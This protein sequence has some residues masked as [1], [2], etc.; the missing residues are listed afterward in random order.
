MYDCNF[1]PSIEIY[2]K[3]SKIL[4]CVV[5]G[6]VTKGPG[7]IGFEPTQVVHPRTP[8]S[9]L[10]EVFQAVQWQHEKLGVSMYWASRTSELQNSPHMHV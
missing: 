8:L 2:S 5:S 7:G 3:L 4:Y 6:V 10:Y 1:D 9:T